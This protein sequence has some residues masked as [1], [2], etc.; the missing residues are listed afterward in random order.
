MKVRLLP[1]ATAL[2]LTASAHAA[3]PSSIA[4]TGDSITRAFNDCRFDSNA[5]FN[6]A[7]TRCDVTTRD[8]FH[9]SVSGQTKLAAVTWG[10][11]ASS[12]PG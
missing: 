10:Q 9:L 12:C 11:V 5:V 6:T 7:F 3:Y 2:T 1:L 8:Y 4:S